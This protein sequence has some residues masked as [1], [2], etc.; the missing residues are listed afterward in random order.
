MFKYCGP[1]AFGLTAAL[2][3]FSL[4]VSALSAEVNVETTLALSASQQKEFDSLA[5]LF[6]VPACD[7]TPLAQSLDRKTPCRAAAFLGPFAKWLVTK[8]KTFDECMKDC[9]ARYE[10]MSSDKRLGIDHAGMPV[11]GDTLAPVHIVIYISAMCPLCKYLTSEICREV[12]SGALKGKASLLAKPFT[13]GIGDRA[14]LAA[15][16]S[17]KYWDY[18]ALL[19]NIKVRPDETVLL[20]VADSL[21]MPKAA[22]KALLADTSIV[23]MLAGFRAEGERNGVTLTPTVFI[24]GKRYHS[25]KDPRW[26]LDAA[27]YEYE[28]LEGK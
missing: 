3:L 13:A 2:L 10:S 7:S 11:A 25:Y 4:A 23:S 12:S 9:A 24:D 14:L 21:G 5:A 27:L 22:F 20:R 6:R 17:G 8:G 1:S 26:V 19:H 28:T 16:R 18:I 15:A